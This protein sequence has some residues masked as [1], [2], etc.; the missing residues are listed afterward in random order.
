MPSVVQDSVWTTKKILLCVYVKE[1]ESE[2]ILQNLPVYFCQ[3][4]AR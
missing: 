1:N 2:P 4:A 3:V